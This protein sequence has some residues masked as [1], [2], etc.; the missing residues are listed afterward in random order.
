MLALIVVTILLLMLW[1]LGRRSGVTRSELHRVLPADD[2]VPD[3]NLVI[4]RAVTLPAPVSVVWP[5]IVQLGKGRAGW[6]A[7]NWLEKVLVW[8]KSR[9][10]IRYIREDLQRLRDGDVVEDWGPA[11]LQVIHLSPQQS[12]QYRGITEPDRT[13]RKVSNYTWVLVLNTHKDNQTRLHIRLRITLKRK[14]TIIPVRI[15]GGFIDYLT[16]V[17][18]FAGLRERLK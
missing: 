18:L 14:L 12:V 1:R 5:W 15:A 13:N 2:V 4:D 16:I 17:I 3:A 7:P 8:K 9:R 11:S 10:G 6:Y